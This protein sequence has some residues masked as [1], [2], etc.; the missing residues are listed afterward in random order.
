MFHLARL[1]SSSSLSL[2]ATIGYAMTGVLG[3]CGRAGS[4]GKGDVLD[5][6]AAPCPSRLPR[7]YPD[8]KQQRRTPASYR[9][10]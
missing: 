4:P 7:F 9:H 1:T 3:R 5:R 8:S 2:S 10:F 6:F